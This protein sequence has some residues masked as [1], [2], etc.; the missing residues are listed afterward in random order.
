MAFLV[1]QIHDDRAAVT[2]SPSRQT[3]WDRQTLKAV[4]RADRRMVL[5]RRGHRLE[6]VHSGVTRRMMPANTV[7]ACDIAA[8]AAAAG[9]DITTT[10]AADTRCRSGPVITTTA[11]AAHV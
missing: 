9:T 7:T 5:G 4:N 10:A 3:D 8:T 1:I 2:V 6:R 11:A